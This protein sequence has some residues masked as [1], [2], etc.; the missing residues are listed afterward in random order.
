MAREA[1][2]RPTA[3]DKRVSSNAMSRDVT[4]Y[5]L[6]RGESVSAEKEKDDKIYA[7]PEANCLE[8]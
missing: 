4:S 5:G 3:A 1:V 7:L 2:T 8:R 6:F